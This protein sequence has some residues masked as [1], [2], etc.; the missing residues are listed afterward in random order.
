MAK[1][2]EMTRVARERALLVQAILGRQGREHAADSIEELERL[3]DTAGAVVV[4]SVTQRRDRPTHQYFVGE[5]KLEDIRVACREADANLVIFDN[6][7][8]PLQVN[9]LDVALGVKVIDRSELIL[10]IFARRARSAEAQIQVELAQ[11]QYLVS[12]LP[13]SER[14]P[15]FTGGI[16]MR[17]PGESPLRLRNEPMRKRIRDLQ[18]KLQAVQD[19]RTRT[20]ERRPWPTVSLVGYTNAG[21]STLLNAL[22]GAECYVDDRL[23]ATLDTKSRLLRL[24]DGREALLTDTVGFIR[25]LPHSLVASFRSTLDE[26]READLLLHVADASHPYVRDHCEVV[27]DTLAG[28]GAEAVPTV[29]ALNKCDRPEA[30]AQRAALQADFPDALAISATEG[31]G[32]DALRQRIAE[33]LPVRPARGR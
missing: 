23:F 3:A 24:P 12:R 31:G 15:R 7:L 13:V 10:Q 30:L 19:R 29:L 27:F 2:P 28:I 11:L 6:E 14:Q 17:G 20:R 18:E 21:K 25:H 16:G 5:G 26:V 9:K 32:L 1:A 22:S 8:S 4:G 33:R